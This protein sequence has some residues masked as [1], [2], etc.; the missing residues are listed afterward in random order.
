MAHGTSQILYR[1]FRPS[2][3]FLED[4]CKSER[5]ISLLGTC[6]PVAQHRCAS[7][8]QFFN[9]LGFLPP[10]DNFEGSN[11]SELFPT[12]SLL[13]NSCSH[14]LRKTF[15]HFQVLNPLQLCALPAAAVSQHFT[16][17][18][19]PELYSA[20]ALLTRLL[21]STF[22]FVK[23]GTIVIS[24]ELSEVNSDFCQCTPCG[25]F[26]CTPCRK[27]THSDRETIETH[28]LPFFSDFKHST[29]NHSYIA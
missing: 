19:K 26:N 20:C 25:Q 18:T 27:F 10:F 12:S 14:S 29:R 8:T 6:P 4:F 15:K 21:S 3:S 22:T 5:N 2:I 28:F 24:P 9:A 7:L 1:E 11:P 17:V 16:Q 13:E 23:M